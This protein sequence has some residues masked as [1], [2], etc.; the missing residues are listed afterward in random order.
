VLL[1]SETEIDSSN[2]RRGTIW[3]GREGGST[4]CDNTM[5]AHPKASAHANMLESQGPVY[6][7]DFLRRRAP[8]SPMPA[9]PV[10][11]T[12][13]ETGSG[14]VPPGIVTWPPPTGT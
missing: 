11:T 5:G 7:D 14:V 6:S 2:G 13:M 4:L 3:T 9:S 12:D 8:K 1:P 10:A